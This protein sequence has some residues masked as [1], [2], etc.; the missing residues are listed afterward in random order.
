MGCGES[1]SDHKI[2][3]KVSKRAMLRVFGEIAKENRLVK[4]VSTPLE[5]INSSWCRS[6]A[7][8]MKRKGINFV[9]GYHGGV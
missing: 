4:V 6:M 7:T 8:R 1:G 9:D 3:I 2:N 5:E